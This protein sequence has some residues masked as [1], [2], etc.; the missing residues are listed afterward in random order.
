MDKEKK[1]KLGIIGAA[2]YSGEELL[3]ILLNHPSSEISFITS[4]K[5]AGKKIGDI[6]PRFNNYNIIFEYPDLSLIKKHNVD[7]VFLALPHGLAS[8]YAVP[9]HDMGVKV[10]DISADFRLNSKEKYKEFYDINHPAPSLLKKSVYGLAEIYKN[11][12]IK[13]DIIACPGCY[14]TSILLPLIPLLNE[15]LIS[16]ENIIVA[17]GSGVSGAGRKVDLPFIFPECNESFRA[18]S[19]SGHR[20]LSEIEQEISIA[21]KEEVIINF[22]PH[23]VPMNRGINSTIIVNHNNI[24]ENKIRRVFNKYYK[25]KPFIR[26]LDSKKFSDTKNVTR[27]NVCE[28]GFTFDQR[29]NKLIITSAI[30]NLTKG[31]AGQAVQCMNIM[32]GI[33]ETSGLV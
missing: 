28:I 32:F 10:I 21:A 15:K 8:E 31:A 25:D 14:P 7:V 18:Y 33:E 2:G 24:N 19:V 29:T 11:K 20:H 1:V 3:R 23:L 27:T 9:I 5:Y 22:I 13:S 16:T 4:R 17:S 6:F 12:I 30:D 26:V